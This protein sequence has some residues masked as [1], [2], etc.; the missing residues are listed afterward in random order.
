MRTRLLV[1]ATAAFLFFPVSA[2]TAAGSD[3]HC[4][5]SEKTCDGRPGGMMEKCEERAGAAHKCDED[6]RG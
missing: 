6:S 4:E 2:A 1:A 3:D 5:G